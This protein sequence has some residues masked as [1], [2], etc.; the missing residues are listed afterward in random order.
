MEDKIRL[1]LLKEQP[2][3]YIEGS[4]TDTPRKWTGTY[5]GI[6]EYSHGMCI[7]YVPYKSFML[8]TTLNINNLGEKSVKIVG[9]G[10]VLSGYPNLLVYDS[11]SDSWF[12][13]DIDT[14][15]YYRD[16]PLV[17]TVDNNNGY[18]YYYIAGK[19]ATILTSNPGYI[20]LCNNNTINLENITKIAIGSNSI[21]QYRKPV[22]FTS[23]TGE[24][25]KGYHIAYYDGETVYI[26]TDGVIPG[27]IEKAKIAETVEWNEVEGDNEDVSIRESSVTNS[28]YLYTHD[29]TNISKKPSEYKNQYLTSWFSKT[30]MPLTQT[31]SGI[32]IS[33]SSNNVN[34]QL[35]S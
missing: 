2:I 34:W 35:C 21:S 27:K 11:V 7:W 31:F 15:T 1:N 14:D 25:G 13:C 20:V 29:L 28:L 18:I 24:M 32:N 23:T 30:D 5:D 3:P 26:N 6:T 8:T 33:S 12:F 16:I 10:Q 9:G 22:V 17:N 4:D 19:G